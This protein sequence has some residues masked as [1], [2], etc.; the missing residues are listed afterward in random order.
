M[1]D[2]NQL[3]VELARALIARYVV[4]TSQ[5]KRHTG[6]SAFAVSADEV[7]ATLAA[8]PPVPDLTAETARVQ[9]TRVAL[10]DACVQLRSPLGQLVV[11]FKL[12]PIDVDIVSILLA[13]ERDHDLERVISFALDDFTRKRPD[14]AFLARVIGADGDP[15]AVTQ[16]FDEP[17]PLRRHG[18]VTFAAGSDVAA[19]LRSVRLSDRVLAFLRAHDTVDELVRGVLSIRGRVM[20]VDQIVMAPVLIEEI[21]RAL[22]PPT[23]RVVLCGP[24]GTGRALAA[25]AIYAESG[26]VAIRID[27]AGII[28]EGRIGERLT[29]AL[30]EVVLRRGAAILDATGLSELPRELRSAIVVASADLTIPL[31]YLVEQPAAWLT[32]GVYGLVEVT[33]PAPNFRQ[34]M[35]LWQ[36]ALPPPLAYDNDLEVVA[37]RYAFTATAISNAA[38]RAATAA[39]LRDPDDGVVSLDELTEA[40]RLMFSHRLGTMAQRVPPG[41]TWED[42]VVPPDTLAAL[43]EVVRFARNKPFLL[44][45]WGFAKKL[46]YGRGVSAILA[47]PPGTGKT[48]VAQL[49]AKE[50]GFDLYRIDVSQIVNKY[51]GETEKNLARL[52]DEAENS[53]AVLFFDEADSLFSKRTDVKSSNDRYANLEVNYLLQRMEIYD[54]VTLLATNLEQGLDEAFKRRVRFSVQFE[55]PSEVERNRLWQSMFP[56]ETPLAPGIDWTTLAAKFEMSGGYIKKAVLRA[57]LLAIEERR[58]VTMTDLMEAAR[59]E[60]REMGRII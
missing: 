16:R 11:M 28:E 44:E 9:A 20:P 4:A 48:M 29:A 19:S 31:V 13:P 3:A 34:R 36:Q 45:E 41:F 6:G 49:L 54:G 21:R 46:P 5:R 60:Y 43:R 25:E 30:R 35:A 14:I 22:A 10:Y 23:A 12:D 59:Q 33:V 39:R 32:H 26:R 56:V 42:L 58:A 8:P 53:H 17:H 52:F 50:I 24:S 2:V 55:L 47:G 51:I 38:R 40:S 27:L 37:A 1:T 7:V 18:L 15:D 57:A